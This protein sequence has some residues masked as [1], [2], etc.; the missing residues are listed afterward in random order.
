VDTHFAIGLILRT[1]E[2]P[3]GER[4]G[5]LESSA[6]TGFL[7]LIQDWGICALASFFLSNTIVPQAQKLAASHPLSACPG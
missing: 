1:A 2:N 6:A 7:S 5:R 3:H 4:V